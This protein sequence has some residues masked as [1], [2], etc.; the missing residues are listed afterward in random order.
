MS[1]DRED[2]HERVIERLD[3]LDDEALEWLDTLLSD[4]FGL[5]PADAG[6]DEPRLLT[7]R[8]LLGGLVAGSAMLGGTNLATAWYAREQ[9]TTAGWQM[10]VGA[11][12]AQAMAEAGKTHQEMQ[13]EIDALRGL[14]AHYEALEDSNLERVVS[15]SIERFEPSLAGLQGI[16]QPLMDGIGTVRGGLERFEAAVPAIRQGMAQVDDTL[17]SLDERLDALREVLADVIER[18]EPIAESLGAFFDALLDRLP[19]GMGQRIEL[20]VL[21]LRQLVDG[22][23]DTVTAVRDNLLTPLQS[24]WFNDADEGDVQANLLTPV[25]TNVLDPAEQLL[26]DLDV[27][28]ENWQREVAEPVQQVLAERESLRRSLHEYK[29]RHG[30][31]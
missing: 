29:N 24:A 11:G 14:I 5:A 20:V 30:L 27:A 7:R 21:R 22:V 23:P 13:A 31:S 6:E 2:L 19:F 8:Q 25:R 1:T 16:T 9:G 3:Q 17:D 28:T 4:N 18:T 12:E 15:Q 26:S 10:G